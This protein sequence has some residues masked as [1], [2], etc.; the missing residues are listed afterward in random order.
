M[1]IRI[2]LVAASLFV[3]TALF[4][5]SANIADALK[6]GKISG[7]FG[8]YA[9]QNSTK[10]SDDGGYGSGS[11]DLGFTTDAL[12]GFRLDVGSRA[13]H[14]FWEVD[15]GEYNSDTKAILHTANIGYSNEYFD[16][17]FGRQVIELIWM[18][19]F[20]EALVGVIKTVPNTDIVIGYSQ[21]RAVADF[22]R[23]LEGFARLGDSGAFV[24][25]AKWRGI[26]GL[27]VNPFLYYANDVAAW[28]GAK[29]DYDR[30]FATFS[31]GGTAEYTQ[32]DEDRGSDGSFLRLEA[33]GVFKDIGAKVGFIQTD[34]NGGAG[35]ITAA[36]ENL[37]LFE[38]GD[39]VFKAD[40]QTFYIGANGKWR[41]FTFGGILG[42]TEYAGGKLR[43]ID[44]T[45]AY[46]LTN[47]LNISAAFIN[48]NGNGN[49]DDYNKVTAGVVYSF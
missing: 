49:S 4:A 32:S 15:G 16:V 47:N 22:D 42:N 8:I 21:R 46:E 17:V 3:G 41:Q 20:H 12:Y 27:V 19:D 48:G 24:A 26:S 30:E 37:N 39:Q 10:N 6:N 25:D 23:P 14:A 36:G 28:A 2:S 35:N 5:D 11:F 38:D 34:K 44:I 33:R 1:N 29:V 9:E 31:L 40:A 13:N 43:E 45:A 18:E 7:E